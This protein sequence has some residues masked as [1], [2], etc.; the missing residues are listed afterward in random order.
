MG[1]IGSDTR[2]GI[3]MRMI[4]GGCDEDAACDEDAIC[5][6]F[7]GGGASSLELLELEYAIGIPRSPLHGLGR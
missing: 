1:G 3:G 4:M 7:F 5:E 2:M 6:G